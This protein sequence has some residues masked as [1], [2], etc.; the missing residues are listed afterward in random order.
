MYSEPAKKK[1][2]MKS[3]ILQAYVNFGLQQAICKPFCILCSILC[4]HTGDEKQV[5]IGKA[6]KAL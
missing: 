3:V 1:G 2:K 6:N 5:L 4:T